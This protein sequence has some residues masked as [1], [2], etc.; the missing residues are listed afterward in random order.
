MVTNEFLKEDSDKKYYIENPPSSVICTKDD[1]LMTRTGNTGKVVTDV[2][3]AFHNNFFKIKYNAARHN[4][5]FLYFMLTSLSIQRKISQLAG[6]STIPDLN[7]GDFYSILITYPCLAEQQK[8][9]N[10]LSTLDNKIEKEEEKLRLLK[11]QKK[12]FVQQMF[13]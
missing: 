9:A 8:I 3:G 2:E 13:V 4:K 6:T 7:H 1:I 10:L 5:Y 11:E 12:A